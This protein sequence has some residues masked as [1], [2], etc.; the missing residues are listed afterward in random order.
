VD[1]N[2]L[3]ALGVGWK[4]WTVRC[5]LGLVVVVIVISA[6]CGSGTQTRSLVDN[7]VETAE[8]AADL[9]SVA[10]SGPPPS[11]LPDGEAGAVTTTTDLSMEGATRVVSRDLLANAGSLY[12][13]ESA[14]PVVWEQ[15]LI[16]SAGPSTRSAIVADANDEI[17]VAGTGEGAVVAIA[18]M[19]GDVLWT[20]DLTAGSSLEEYNA[21]AMYPTIGADAVFIAAS[22]GVV[23]ALDIGTGAVLWESPVGGLFG[24]FPVVVDDTVVVARSIA[25]IYD[26]M[27]DYAGA[28][29]GSQGGVVAVSASTGELRWDLPTSLW[30]T[31]VSGPGSTVLVT[32][33][34]NQF[35]GNGAVELLDAATGD[36]VWTVDDMDVVTPAA[37]GDDV[38]V[39]AAAS[40]V[41]LD[42][43]GTVL[44]RTGPDWCSCTFQ[45]PAIVDDAVVVVTNE[46]AVYGLDVASGRTCWG[47]DIGDNY[48]IAYP[49]SEGFLA[50][51]SG[52][53]AGWIDAGT[54][55]VA[56]W[57]PIQAQ[58]LSVI[59]TAHGPI[60]SS[61]DGYVRLLGEPTTSAAPANSSAQAQCAD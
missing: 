52:G 3:A 39:V 2:L 54:G 25:D 29:V 11:G 43:D 31:V 19:T 33:F 48:G 12:V 47:V 55:R 18:L 35:V 14:A 28:G 21:Y 23:Y 7:S 27:V 40:L 38:V 15:L 41:V 50:I 46:A 20:R 26:D 42:D 22:T 5:S 4:T 61:S 8:G 37:V 17:V 56:F 32:S 36:V 53:A 10:T 13:A 60:V 34:D 30:S 57:F 59:P 51:A 24:G 44:W 9:P 1:L 49:G 6:G 45:F 16:A 58:V